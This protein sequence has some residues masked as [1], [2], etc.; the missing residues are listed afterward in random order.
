MG[1]IEPHLLLHQMRCSIFA[2]VRRTDYSSVLATVTL[3][4][5]CEVLQAPCCGIDSYIHGV[6]P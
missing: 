6:L 3:R 1:D 5:A 2:S 4:A